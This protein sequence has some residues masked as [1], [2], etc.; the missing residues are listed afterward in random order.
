MT[1]QTVTIGGSIEGRC[2]K[3]RKN[4]SHIIVTLSDGSPAKVRCTACDREHPFRPPTIPKKTAARRAID[5]KIA[6]REEW[7]RLQPDMEMAKACDYSMDGTYKAKALI[8]HPNFGL[9]RVLRIMGDRKVE[10]LF[11]DGKKI[12]R[13]K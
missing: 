7:Q 2:T 10:V 8:N 13:C 11:E 3:C 4:L 6:E 1:N 9:G 12:M 5:P